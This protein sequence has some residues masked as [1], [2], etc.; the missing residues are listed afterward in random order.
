MGAADSAACEGV[1]Q[2]VPLADHLALARPCHLGPPARWLQVN[3]I[4]LQ[5][6]IS[7]IISFGHIQLSF[8]GVLQVYLWVFCPRS[9]HSLLKLAAPAWA[10]RGAPFNGPHRTETSPPAQNG[11]AAKQK[12]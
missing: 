8:S 11:N 12:F 9:F 6:T 1:P 4:E 10:G 3:T 2:T 5:S 7:M